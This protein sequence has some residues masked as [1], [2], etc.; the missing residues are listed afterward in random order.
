V[1]GKLKGVIDTVGPDGLVLDVQGVGYAVHCSA[2][3]LAKL[4]GPGEAAILS[5]ETVVR[6]DMIRLYGFDTER[7]RD[8]FR[9]LQS[10]Q[11]VGAKVALAILGVLDEQGLAAAIAGQDGAA[12]ARA[13]GVG[14]KLAKR[15][16][17]ELKDKAPAGAVFLP[18]DRGTAAPAQPVSE[19]ALARADA[20]SALVNLGFQEAQAARAVD[21]AAAKL[22]EEAGLQALIRE[23]LKDLQR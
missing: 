19:A 1:I 18:S 10:V 5:I 9:L 2:R 11:G 17:S 4:P 13:Q 3:T 15:I 14:P 6:E 21:G 12:V 16:V 23:G 20:V 8:W 22:G 7:E